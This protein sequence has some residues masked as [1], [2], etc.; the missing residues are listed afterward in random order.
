[1][2]YITGPHTISDAIE[3][4][5]QYLA[6]KN[7]ED[8]WFF[9]E[10]SAAKDAVL[11]ELKTPALGNHITTL[12]NF[13]E[14]LVSSHC[15]EIKF[16]TLDEQLIIF[17]T[18]VKKS[19]LSS[20]GKKQ[21]PISFI[22]ELIGRYNFF[23][24][25]GISLKEFK[26]KSAKHNI[27]S[28]IFS[29]YEELCG[30]T[31]LDSTGILEKAVEILKIEP[32]PCAVIYRIR[33]A[34]PL[35]QKLLDAV[36]GYT[37]EEKTAAGHSTV[38]EFE[39]P[40]YDIALPKKPCVSIERYPTSRDEAEAVLDKAASLIE[41]GVSPQD[42]LL[43]YPG[44]SDAGERIA[45]T[46]SDI[47]CRY[48]KEYAPRAEGVPEAE[49]YPIQISS[50]GNGT[51][52]SSLPVMQCIISVLSAAENEF[53]L[54]DL[55]T[56]ISSP[57][58]TAAGH[59]ACETENRYLK[60]TPGLLAQISVIAGVRE[61]KYEWLG[62]E[63]KLTGKNKEGVEEIRPMFK[64]R[65]A[66]FFANI[67]PL[68]SWIESVRGGSAKHTFSEWSALLKD[69]ISSSGWIERSSP[70]KVKD[71]L[72]RYLDTISQKPAGETKVSFSEFTRHIR[73]F[74]AKKRINTAGADK[75]SCIRAAKIRNAGNLS[76]KH[77]FIMGLSADTLPNIMQTLSPFTVEETMEL[78]PALWETQEKLER[79][80]FAA[81][82]QTAEET[83]HLSCAET[84]AARRLVP[85]PY[86]T[87]LGKL[88]DITKPEITHSKWHGQITAGKRLT[89]A[90]RGKDSPAELAGIADA[91]SL[92]LRITRELAPGLYDPS[93]SKAP[94]D[95][96]I[97][98]NEDADELTQENPLSYSEKDAAA[99]QPQFGAAYKSASFSPTT[100]E[101]YN[102]CPYK[103]F[104]KHHMNLYSAG[105]ALAE[106]SLTGTVVHD[107]LQEFI[108]KHHDLLTE[109]K[110]EDAYSTL[111]EIVSQKFAEY[112]L[113][114]PSWEA[115]KQK[116]LDERVPEINILRQF[117]NDEIE[118]AGTWDTDKKYLEMELK[119]EISRNDKKLRIYGK[120]DRVLRNGDGITI[121]DYKTGSSFAK[122]EM[123]EKLL[124]IPLYLEACRTQLSKA[125]GCGVKPADGY[126]LQMK[127]GDY[128][129]V[130]IYDESGKSKEVSKAETEAAFKKVYE[131]VLDRA[132]E[133]ADEMKQGICTP[134][135]ECKDPYCEYASICRRTV[136][137]ERD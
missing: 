26:D 70:E 112:P 8:V 98:I 62:I 122:K 5:K 43:L 71:Y 56:I 101:A 119:T 48:P 129:H 100:L 18:I 72:F 113:G 23:R 110:K 95:D 123:K 47:C 33:P 65:F 128:K 92:C 60:L 54:E 94:E 41:N 21:I 77:V 4:W 7:P 127:P 30:S 12:G 103:W 17:D 115:S 35:L 59:F 39:S 126:Y 32:V 85:S 79:E 73:H 104:L 44:S 51:A 20:G 135:G 88:T 97:T 2:T 82:L 83:L 89:A 134:P 116:F 27:L 24:L 15:P 108:E 121:I 66:A 25:R 81:A 114:T 74:A 36:R 3:T 37:D 53:P 132:F 13:A 61:K 125:E 120:A 109:E 19:P 130:S 86:L 6:D 96:S 28:D 31:M 52:L 29:G 107:A 14:Q 67:E 91:K 11:R 10:N 106:H 87:K 105:E 93:F 117:I 75:N 68:I 64:D 42:I 34:N 22:N 80:N 69:W 102:T 136:E 1:M 137:K 63:K 49:L 9:V 40:E 45:D 131:D 133:I 118:R 58:F 84:G 38:T 55:Q 16:L 99:L 57:Y 124:Q 90:E 111:K 46:M 50:S 76:A 78:C